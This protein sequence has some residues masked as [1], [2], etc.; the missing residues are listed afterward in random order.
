MKYH[1]PVSTVIISLVVLL[2]FA[3]VALFAVFSIGM[4]SPTL[5]AADRIMDELEAGVTFLKGK[6]AYSNNPKAVILCVMR[7]TIAPKAEEIVKQEDPLAFMIISSATE[8]YGEGYKNIF[9]E[10]L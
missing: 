4:T 9:S 1:S 3:S 5:I 7:N 2:L 8:I 6:G 10:K